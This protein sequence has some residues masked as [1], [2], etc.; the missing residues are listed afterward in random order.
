M[1]G[2]LKGSKEAD[3]YVILSNHYDAWIYGAIDPNSGTAILAEIAR[4][5]K[6]AK[7]DGVFKPT[8]S[9]MFCNWDAEE[10]GLIV[11]NNRVIHIIL[12]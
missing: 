5:M 8:R 4:A 11:I 7:D 1:V 12:F 3:R 6:A 2:Y 9:I 10:Y